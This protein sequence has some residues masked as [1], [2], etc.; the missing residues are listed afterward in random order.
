MEDVPLCTEQLLER[1]RRYREI[2]TATAAP[3]V[4]AASHQLAD[5]YEALAVEHDLV[6]E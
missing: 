3:I 2:A 6:Q 5:R 4:A 1:A